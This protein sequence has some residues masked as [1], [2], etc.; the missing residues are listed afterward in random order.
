M[1]ILDFIKNAD[2]AFWLF[3]FAFV[4]A[5]PAGAT[6]VMTLD[7][8]EIVQQ[9]DVIADVTVTN[10]ESFWN[11]PAGGKAIHTR[12][13]F[14]LN[15]TPLK[16]Q[17]SSL[18][19]L[20]FLGGVAGARAMRVAGMPQPQ[21]GDRLIIFSYAPDKIF[22]SPIIGFDQGALRIVR[23]QEDNIDRVY[24]WWGQ[25]VNKWESFTSR[26][27]PSSAAATAE[28]LHSAN[29]VDEFLQRVSTMIHP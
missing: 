19:Y 26:V 15:R 20:D 27:P 13:T 28:Q 11:A 29:S 4:F 8:P 3:P 7:L 14:Q 6:T 21:K 12:V 1:E 25:P 18:F 23:G 22:A 24:R 5:L 2:H 16:G 17:I 10:V 9:A